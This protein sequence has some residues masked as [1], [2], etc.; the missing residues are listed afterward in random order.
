MEQFQYELKIPK[1]RIAV[2]IGKD[3]ITKKEIEDNTKTH[4]NVDSKE[5]EV[6]ISGD[7]AL[8]LYATREVVKAIGRG[9]NP[10]IAQLL[11]KQDYVF[12]VLSLPDYVGK[13]KDSML[14]LKG[15]VIGKEGKSRK[16]IEELTECDIC[17][18]G[19]TVSIIGKSENASIAKR[20]VE[21][22]LKGTTHANVFKFL[23]K[24]RRELKK[25]E[26]IEL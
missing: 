12:E 7:D 15:R 26:V 20:A 1:E 14:R 6:F 9:F 4:L 23:E 22:L 19:K 18:Y 17:V 5:G 2:L 25:K 24:Q 3:G 10:D 11:L 8:G 13:S 16:I 21:S